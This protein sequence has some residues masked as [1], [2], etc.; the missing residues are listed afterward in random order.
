MKAGLHVY[1]FLYV[2]A[3]RNVLAR[4]LPSRTQKKFCFLMPLFFAVLTYARRLRE[5]PGEPRYEDHRAAW[6]QGLR[7]G[8]SSGTMLSSPGPKQKTVESSNWWVVLA[9]NFTS[10]DFFVIAP[11]NSQ[12]VLV[13]RFIVYLV[14]QLRRYAIRGLFV[15]P[16]TPTIR[17]PAS[18]CLDP[19]RMGNHLVRS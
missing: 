16:L 13:C 8:R 5:G 9:G 18:T 10:V 2:S 11:N 14:R 19:Y 6:R 17:C 7:G 3:V 12:V 1:L 4:V 15:M